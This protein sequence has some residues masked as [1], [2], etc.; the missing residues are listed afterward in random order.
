[1]NQ[2]NLSMTTRLHFGPGIIADAL[3][4]EKDT[5]KGNILIVTTGRSL[6]KLGY[7]EQLRTYLKKLSTVDEVLIYEKISQNPETKEIEQAVRLGKDKNVTVVI[8]F[9]GGSAI[10]AAKATAVG[11]ASEESV[12]KILLEGLEPSEE[13]LPIVAIPTTAGTGSELSKAAIVS[14]SEHQF[15]GGI[16]GNAVL[17]AVAIVDPQYTYS[18]PIRIT[19]ETG[20]DALA[21]AI[22]SYVAVKAN[23]FSEMLSE[24]AICII[25]ENIRKLHCCLDNDTARDQ[26]SYAS[27]IMGMNLANVGT[28]LPHRMQYVVGVNTHTTHGAGLL[29]LY[30]AWL[31]QEYSVNQEKVEQVFEWLN[32]G[33]VNSEQEVY[34]KFKAFLQELDSAYSLSSFGITEEMLENMTAKVTGN[35]ANDRL[36]ECKNSIYNIFRDALK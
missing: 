15:K 1:M 28:C 19:M 9:G 3:Q 36:S 7:L 33:R 34:Q 14:C 25:G 10:D 11:I 6:K 4:Q 32:L 5:I 24:K 26:M 23:T 21:H 12:E 22:E 31:A 16:R 2:F 8:G 35:I 17:P 13:T 18:V 27:M 30:P 20:F 29:A